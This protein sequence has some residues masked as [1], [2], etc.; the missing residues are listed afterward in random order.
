MLKG[1]YGKPGLR[2]RFKIQQLAK[3]ALLVPH[4]HA[5]MIEAFLKQWNC[6]YAKAKVTMA[7]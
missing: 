6:E 5:D 1:R 3:G 4:E 2:E 7:A